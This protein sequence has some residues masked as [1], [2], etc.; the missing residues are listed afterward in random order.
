[1]VYVKYDRTKAVLYARKWAFSRNPKYLN[2]DHFGGDC[3]NFASQC[4]FAGCNIMNY[5]PV[6]GWYYNNGNDKTPSWSGV[7]FLYNF[8][9]NNN[10]EGPYAVEIDRSEVEPGDIIQLGTAANHFYHSSVV[11]KVTDTD[12]FIAAHTFDSYMR[13]I[14]SYSYDKIRYIHILGARQW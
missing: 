2:F 13:N 4:I 8:L 11:M 6:L 9:T 3:T 12:I 14:S 10:K 7:E 1:M 5:T